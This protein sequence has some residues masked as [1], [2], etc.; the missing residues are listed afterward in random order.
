MRDGASKPAAAAPT[1]REPD[2]SL[3]DGRWQQPLHGLGRRNTLLMALPFA[4]GA[5]GVWL[6]LK[7]GLPLP[8]FLGSM[9]AVMVAT[10]VRLPVERA[11]FIA[12]P[13]RTLIGFTVGTSFTPGLLDRIGG[14]TASL[15]VMIP[16]TY[17]IVALGMWVFQR[18]AG[19]DRPTSFFAAVPGGLND[20]VLMAGDAGAQERSVTLAH[21]TRIFVVICTLPLFIQYG[22]GYQI[23]RGSVTRLRLAQLTPHDAVIILAIAVGGYLLAR[24]LKIAGAPVIGPMVLSALAHI[25]GLTTARMP[26]EMMNV[27]Q[28]GLGVLL[29]CRF[30]GITVKEL[31]TIVSVS[32][33]FSLAILLLSAAVAG[34]VHTA[35]GIPM[36]SVLL[37]YAPGGQ[38]ELLL[39][40]LVLGLDAPYVALHHLMRL[41]TVIIGAQM[42][43]RRAAWTK[44]GGG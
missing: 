29:G 16:L 19:F 26:V 43:F 1:G 21:I 17:A 7:L 8:W 44:S 23:T 5:C 10:F 42:V 41:F 30:K 22:L 24:R 6:F 2:R 33:V 9:A 27:A 36:L 4:L 11:G 18:F 12:L 35:L 39:I 13:L 20:M 25:T 31:T 38:T 37:A 15:L 3:W 40:A 28:L 14:M 34:L 32:A